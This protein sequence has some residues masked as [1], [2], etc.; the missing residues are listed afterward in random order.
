L[1]PRI[2]TVVG[3]LFAMSLFIVACGGDDD[4]DG[5]TTEPSTEATETPEVTGDDGISPSPTQ[6]PA[7]TSAGM[8]LDEFVIR[9]DRTRARRGTV[10]FVV[11]NEGQLEHEFVVLRTDIEKDELPRKA[12]DE[13]VD[14]SELDVVGRIPAFPPGET[15]DLTIDVEEGQYIVLCNLYANGESHYLEGMYNEFEVTPTAAVDTP[16]PVTQ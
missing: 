7:D 2:L 5:P 11:R 16:T 13:G 6:Q 9:P 15:R 1:N 12:N 10:T 8:A 14:E 3:L 4:G